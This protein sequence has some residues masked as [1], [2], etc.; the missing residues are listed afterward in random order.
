V[1]GDLAGAFVDAF[2]VGRLGR[3]SEL[4][5]QVFREAVGES[6]AGFEREL[7]PRAPFGAN[8]FDGLERDEAALAEDA[9]A[10]ADLLDLVEVVRGVDDAATAR[11]EVAEDAGHGLS[12]EGIEAAGRFIEDD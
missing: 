12:H 9:D 2:E 5:G 11:G 4:P 6:G 1:V 10:G 3:G 8:L 7:D